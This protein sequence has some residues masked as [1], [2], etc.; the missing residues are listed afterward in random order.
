MADAL[1][2]QKAELKAPELSNRLV[3]PTLQYFEEVMGP[4]RLATVVEE[5]GLPREYLEDATGW[6][7]MDYLE[8]FTA[9]VVRQLGHQGQNLPAYDDPVWRHWHELGRRSLQRDALGPAFVAVS[10][11][12]LTLPTKRI[13]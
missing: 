10:Y 9:A 2:T 13:V 12:H 6:V 3:L 1:P 5:A 7:S 11:T 8:R 4:A